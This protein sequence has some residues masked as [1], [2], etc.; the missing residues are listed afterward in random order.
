MS[1]PQ[2][3]L[4]LGTVLSLG[5]VAFIAWRAGLGP[6]EAQAWR[7]QPRPSCVGGYLYLD[8]YGRWWCIR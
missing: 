6:A 1:M 7:P 3:V 5:V 8:N 4:L 2:W